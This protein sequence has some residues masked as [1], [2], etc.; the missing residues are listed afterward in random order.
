M[1]SVANAIVG[2]NPPNTMNVTANQIAADLTEF[3]T[4]S[5]PEIEI[6]VVPWERD[7]TRLA[8]YFTDPKFSLIYPYQRWH[9]DPHATT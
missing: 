4:P 9:Y 3:I 2:Q 7:P 8:I 6:R 5:Y 1:Q